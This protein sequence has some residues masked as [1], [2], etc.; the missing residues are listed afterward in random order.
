LA[1][2]RR[3]E[4]ASGDWEPATGNHLQRSEISLK[5]LMPNLIQLWIASLNH[6]VGST[7]NTQIDHF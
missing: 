6:F 4:S 2:E 1:S 7:K 5:T 3:S